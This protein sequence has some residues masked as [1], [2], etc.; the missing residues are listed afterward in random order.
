MELEKN[1]LL[2]ADFI[3]NSIQPD[4]TFNQNPARHHRQKPPYSILHHLQAISLLLSIDKYFPSQTYKTVVDKALS[5]IE[6][7]IFQSIGQHNFIIFEEQSMTSWNAMMAIIYAKQ[8]KNKLARPFLLNIESCIK[9]NSVN[10]TPLISGNEETTDPGLVL[11]SILHNKY[12][13]TVDKMNSLIQ[14]IYK[15][16][17]HSAYGIFAMEELKDT[18]E[19]PNAWKEQVY[20]RAYQ[21]NISSMTSLYAAITQQISIACYKKN[22]VL[23]EHQLSMQINDMPGVPKQLNGAFI[24]SIKF[25]EVRI[26]YTI[27]NAYSLLQWIMEETN[28][29]L[30]QECEI[31][32]KKYKNCSRSDDQ[33]V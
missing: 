6:K 14:Q 5:F 1:L 33:L 8:K 26:D 25:P 10:P 28:C 18:A 20:Q 29:R 21:I 4:G 22:L 19:F 11:F 9:K 15:S 2:A 31:I 17:E 7:L 3:C 30:R 12:D 27:Q 32:E 16:R 24:R 13:I 23:L